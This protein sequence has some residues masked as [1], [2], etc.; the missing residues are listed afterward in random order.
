MEFRHGGEVT[1]GVFAV[2]SVLTYDPHRDSGLTWRIQ[3]AAVL[4]RS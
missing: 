1:H 4:I 2:I 3:T